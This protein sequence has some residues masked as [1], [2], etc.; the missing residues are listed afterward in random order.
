MENPQGEEESLHEDLAAARGTV[1]KLKTL[2]RDYDM[3]VA[4]AHDSSWMLTGT[5]E[6][7]MSLLDDDMRNFVKNRLPVNGAP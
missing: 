5:D 6:V 2:E 4:L 7:L 3:H 1:Q